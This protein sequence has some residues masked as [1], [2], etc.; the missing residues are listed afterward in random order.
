MKNKYSLK[1]F[2][3]PLAVI[4]LCGCG[5]TTDAQSSTATVPLKTATVSQVISPNPTST[6]MKLTPN[7]LFPSIKITDKRIIEF[8]FS[9]DDLSLLYRLEGKNNWLAYDFTSGNSFEVEDPGSMNPS[10]D[11]VSSIITEYKLDRDCSQ[12]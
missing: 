3:Y 9:A 11:D 6:S 1:Y 5:F 2:V 8:A 10:L 12:I 4:L 7:E